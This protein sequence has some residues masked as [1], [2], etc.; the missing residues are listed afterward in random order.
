L[1]LADFARLDLRV[2]EVLAARRVPGKDRL[3]ELEVTLGEETRTVAAGIAQQF[4][5][6]ELVG[7]RLVLVA[8][9]KP[10]TIGGVRSH[11]MILAAGAEQPVAL[12]TLDRE[13]P[14]G[15]KVR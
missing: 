4:P 13:C 10:A 14:P 8:N 11:G 6:E 7:K 1:D 15:E 9:L 5:P 3:L 12:V 2:V